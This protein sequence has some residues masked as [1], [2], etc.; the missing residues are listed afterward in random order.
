MKL[1]SVELGVSGRNLKLWTKVKGIDPEIN[2]SG[3]DNG[4]GIDYFT[5]PSTRS[6]VFSLKVN[7]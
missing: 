5:N 4:F 7:Y 3:V 6:F 1:S 2:Q